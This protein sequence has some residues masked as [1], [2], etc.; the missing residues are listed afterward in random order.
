[1]TDVLIYWRDYR[2]NAERPTW[3]WNTNARLLANLRP[4]DR[5]WF[6]TSGKNLRQ[7]PDQAAFLSVAG[8]RYDLFPQ[9]G[10]NDPAEVCNC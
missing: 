4:G 8:D 10:T 3:A 5:L 7:S 9:I 6:V 2:K 1:M